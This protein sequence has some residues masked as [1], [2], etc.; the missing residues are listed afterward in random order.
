MAFLSVRTALRISFTVRV[1]VE[2]IW[3][4]AVFPPTY[5]TFVPPHTASLVTHSITVPICSPSSSALSLNT[6]SYAV[7]SSI[8]LTSTYAPYCARVASTLLWERDWPSGVLPSSS[9]HILS[10]TSKRFHLRNSTCLPLFSG[11]VRFC[12]YLVNTKRVF[13]PSSSCLS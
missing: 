10:S 13:A 5:C 2:S 9:A 6:L 8:S 11:T 1:S 4:L 3:F 7:S 12:P